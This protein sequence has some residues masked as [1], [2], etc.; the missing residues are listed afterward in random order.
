LGSGVHVRFASLRPQVEQHE[1]LDAQLW[2]MPRFSHAPS[3]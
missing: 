3:I 2:Q 1:A